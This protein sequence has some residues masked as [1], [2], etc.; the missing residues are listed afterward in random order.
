MKIEKLDN[1]GRGIAHEDGKIIFINNALPSEDVDY[2]IIYEK[3]KY[4]VARSLN[5]K[6]ESNLRVIPKCPYYNEC[7]GCNLMHIGIDAEDDYKL[8]KVQDIL[9]NNGKVIASIRLIKNNQELFYRNKIT[10]KVRNNEYGYYNSNTH[11][12][13]KILQ[14]L[15]ANRAINA[16]INKHDFLSIEDGEIIIRT[17]Y[18]EEILIEIRSD[19]NVK[20]DKGLIP[21]NVIGIVLNNRTIY[22]NNYFE[23][24]IGDYK[25]RVSYNSFFQVNNY[26]AGEIFNILKNNLKG[27]NLLDLYCGVGTLGISVAH[28]FKRIYGIEVIGNAIKDAK[29]NARINKIDNAFYYV[30]DT[31]KILKD[32]DV[33]FDSI[34]VDP[35]RSGLNKETIT[36]IIELRPKTIA[37]VSCDPMT[38]ARDLSILYDNYYVEKANVLNMF[39]NTYHVECVC[40]LKL[41]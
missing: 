33:Y 10:L 17:N 36:K 8:N 24:Y 5:I 40:I 3:N 28:N 26:M 4:C 20:M 25:F 27:E 19:Y 16:I 30:G 11:E 13:T 34:I 2:E 23:D 41:R 22:K 38:L 32:I 1:Q 12:F 21:K 39:P 9:R 29:T 6:E 18:L 31:A 14:C 15:L 7:G 37:Y 35:P